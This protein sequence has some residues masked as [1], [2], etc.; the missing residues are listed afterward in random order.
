MI[1]YLLVVFSARTDAG[2][3]SL[4]VMYCNYVRIYTKVSMH[5]SHKQVFK[6]TFMFLFEHT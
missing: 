3:A 5:V 6:F 1:F 2:V 4:C